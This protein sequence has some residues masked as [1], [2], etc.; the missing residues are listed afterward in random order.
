MAEKSNALGSMYINPNKE[1]SGET[2][3]K[4]RS[5]INF[6]MEQGVYFNLSL[7]KDKVTSLNSNDKGYVSI[8]GIKSKF[9]K[10]VKDADFFLAPMTKNGSA[11][12]TTA[13]S[14]DNPW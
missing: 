7:H 11:G 5:A 2:L 9:K 12:T 13:T 14:T 8:T 3:D 10:T 1:L 4:V 6:I